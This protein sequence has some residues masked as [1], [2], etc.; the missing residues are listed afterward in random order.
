MK[1]SIKVL[2]LLTFLALLIYFIFKRISLTFSVF[3]ILFSFFFL[4]FFS[5]KII[6][7][8]YGCKKIKNKILENIAEDLSKKAGI[9]KPQIYVAKIKIANA[10]VV[11]KNKKD[12]AICLTEGALKNFRKKEKKAAL[13]YCIACI[14]HDF[15][16]LWSIVA[17]L[18][19][20]I[21]ILANS[22]RYLLDLLTTKKSKIGL[23]VFSFVMAIVALFLH[24]TISPKEKFKADIKASKLLG[25]PYTLIETMKKMEKEKAEGLEW[26]AHLFMVSPLTKYAS[27]LFSTH[28]STGERIRRLRRFWRKNQKNVEFLK[29][30]IKVTKNL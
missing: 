16:L 21:V 11:G 2:L 18:A 30:N 19:G 14:K 23:S 12:C 22:L 6:L 28:P 13:A 8:R 3:L 25:Q 15:I 17:I 26:T 7:K 20:G 4:Y 9:N 5:H 24:L 27:V 29:S 10:F 1:S